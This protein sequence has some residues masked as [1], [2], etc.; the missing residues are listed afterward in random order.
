MSLRNK[1]VLM[2][3]VSVIAGALA[4]SFISYFSASRIMQNVKGVLYA[5]E[6]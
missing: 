1:L 4:L 5:T 2:A 6:K 3:I